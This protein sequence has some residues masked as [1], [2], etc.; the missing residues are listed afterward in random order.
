[1]KELL[2]KHFDVIFEMLVL[3]LVFWGGAHYLA[4]YPSNAELQGWIKGGIIIGVL[5]RAFQSN[6]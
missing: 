6:K 2:D 3:L 5:A 1:M 4:K